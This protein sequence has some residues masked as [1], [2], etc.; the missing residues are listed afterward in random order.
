MNDSNFFGGGIGGTV[1]PRRRGGSIRWNG[2]LGQTENNYTVDT[3][4]VIAGIGYT[5]IAYGTIRVIANFYPKARAKMD[6]I[7]K[8][9]GVIGVPEA[10]LKGA[11]T[12]VKEAI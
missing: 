1:T 11:Q 6:R 5:A 4:S 2:G 12:I 10:T 7:T 9:K 3:S 8:K